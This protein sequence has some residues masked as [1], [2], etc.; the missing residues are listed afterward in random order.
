MLMEYLEEY[1]IS[2]KKGWKSN[3]EKNWQQIMFFVSDA[4]CVRC[5]KYAETKRLAKDKWMRLVYIPQT[6]IPTDERRENNSI[7]TSDW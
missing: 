2:F 3:G 4:D 6:S 7:Q 1:R 5:E